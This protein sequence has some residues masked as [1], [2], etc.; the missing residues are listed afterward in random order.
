MTQYSKPSGP[1]L[2]LKEY[3]VHMLAKFNSE[4]C[5]TCEFE[6]R[7]AKHIENMKFVYILGLVFLIQM[8]ILQL[9]CKKIDKKQN[10]RLDVIE[11][12][13]RQFFFYNN[14]FLKLRLFLKSMNLKIKQIFYL[15]SLK[16]IMFLITTFV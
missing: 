9:N 6:P 3:Q 1:I 13:Y 14:S 5:F 8:D 11:V 12:N 2:N 16:S 4:N 15:I 10:K 7:C